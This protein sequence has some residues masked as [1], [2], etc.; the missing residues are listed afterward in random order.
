MKKTL[1]TLLLSV[2]SVLVIV[3]NTNVCSFAYDT[4]VTDSIV[5]EDTAIHIIINDG[6]TASCQQEEPDIENITHKK[7]GNSLSKKHY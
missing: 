6:S 3:G 5:I 7:D 2:I 1:K 4:D